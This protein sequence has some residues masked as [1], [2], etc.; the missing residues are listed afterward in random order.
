MLLSPG[1]MKIDLCNFKEISP[2][3]RTISCCA[4]NVS[5][6]GQV[7]LNKMLMDEINQHVD[8]FHLGFAHHEE[9][10]RIIALYK[11]ENPNYTFS[12]GG[13]RKDVAFSQSLIEDGITLPARYVVEWN[14]SANAWVGV[15]DRDKDPNAL[16]HTLKKSNCKRKTKHQAGAL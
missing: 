5:P 13:G 1:K 3:R 10:K 12:S 2:P 8:S 14:E 6:K 11:S 16:V 9:D 15:L 4:L 7:S